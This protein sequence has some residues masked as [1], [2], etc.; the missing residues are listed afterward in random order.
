MKLGSLSLSGTGHARKLFV[1]PKIILQRDGRERLV[2][3]FNLD[4]LF[5]L[6]CLVQTIGP[7]PAFH[8]AAGEI[9]DDDDFAVLDHILMIQ[10]VERVRLQ[11]LLDAMQQLHV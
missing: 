7:A 3:L 9:V 1:Q 8:Q 10:S 4:A 11:C 6:D 2:F 5:G